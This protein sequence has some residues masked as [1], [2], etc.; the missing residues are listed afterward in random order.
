MSLD[1]YPVGLLTVTY[2]DKNRGIKSSLKILRIINIDSVIKIFCT[3]R[4][5]KKAYERRIFTLFVAIQ[6][7]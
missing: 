6:V 2:F 5:K 1:S 7:I 3:L 4:V